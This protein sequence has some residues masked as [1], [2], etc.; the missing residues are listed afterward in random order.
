MIIGQTVELDELSNNLKRQIHS[1]KPMAFLKDG[2]Y[3]RINFDWQQGDSA[4]PHIITNSQLMV[5]TDGEGMRRL[6]P[7][8]ELDR[9]IEIGTPYVKVSGKWNKVGFTNASRTTNSITWSRPQ[10]DLSIVFGGHFCK[11]TIE[12]KNGYVPEDNLIAFPVGL[13]GLTRS[14]LNIL[15]NSVPVA[16]LQR[17]IIY[18][19]LDTTKRLPIATA[20]SNIQGQPYL[21]LTLPSHNMSRPII[22]P[23]L[24]LQPDATAGIDVPIG[25]NSGW[26]YGTVDTLY[27]G[28]AGGGGWRGLIKFDLSSLDGTET[29]ISNTFSLYATNDESSNARTVRVF[30]Q[31]RAWT[32]GNKAGEEDNPGT[33]A[34][35][36]RY[37]ATNNWQTAGGFGSDDCEQTDI[38]NLSLTAS[39]TVNQ[40]KNWT[41]T[42]TSKGDLDLGNGWLIKVDT[43]SNDRYWYAS[44][45]NSTAA[46]RPK[47]VIEYTTGGSTPEVVSPTYHYM[48]V[49]GV[50]R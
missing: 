41:L 47:L 26:N 32:E 9:Y 27:I 3:S 46:N 23:T 40:F 15:R 37:D 10:A 20:F 36:F 14:G 17:P 5:S 7:T 48:S 22:D 1:V 12:L 8:H 13:T 28:D 11:L 24:T 50:G 34:T 30:R 6:H 38:G 44:S 19:A 16:F 21:V 33:G 25:V 45:D 39:E 49:L 4:F 18:D 42:P 29:L 31:K 2:S 35:G 43:E